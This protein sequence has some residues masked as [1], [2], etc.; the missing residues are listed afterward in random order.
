MDDLVEL[1]DEGDGLQVFVPVPGFYRELL[2]SDSA[3]YGGG[4][5][6]NADGRPSDPTPWHGHQHSISLTVP[7]LAVVFF[8]PE[9]RRENKSSLAYSPERL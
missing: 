8:K 4:N 7:P 9:R 1:L 3:L 2:N 6:G 5:M